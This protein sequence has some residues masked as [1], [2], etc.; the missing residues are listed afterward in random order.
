[1][2]VEKKNP[3]K[4]EERIFLDLYIYLLTI[5]KNQFKKVRLLHQAQLG[6]GSFLS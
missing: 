5:H 1:M 4:I 3:R 6:G 2:F